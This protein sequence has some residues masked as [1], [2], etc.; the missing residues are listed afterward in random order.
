[1]TSQRYESIG[2]RK[3]KFSSIEAEYPTWMP[4]FTLF[5]DYFRFFYKNICGVDHVGRDRWLTLCNLALPV[6]LKRNYTGLTN[7]VDMLVY[8]LVPFHRYAGGD[9]PGVSAYTIFTEV[10]GRLRQY[11]CFNRRRTSEFLGGWKAYFHSCLPPFSFTPQLYRGH[12]ASLHYQHHLASLRSHGGSGPSAGQGRRQAH[13]FGHGDRRPVLP[14]RGGKDRRG[15]A[16]RSG[17]SRSGWNAG[18]GRHRA[19]TRRCAS[20]LLGQSRRLPTTV[21]HVVWEGAERRGVPAGAGR[22]HQ[23]PQRGQPAV[24]QLALLGSPR[25]RWRDE[26]RHALGRRCSPPR[27]LSRQDSRADSGGEY[28]QVHLP[29]GNLCS[30][31]RRGGQARAEG[32]RSVPVALQCG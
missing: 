26:Q 15:R 20:V 8:S 9:T 1:M 18:L 4:A 12:H 10:H 3:A 25:I 31:L 23:L 28:P 32:D 27:L 21:P 11:S 24:L 29:S 7:S 13:R 22:Q 2:V 17:S 14:D 19:S 16:T 30:G 5:Y 6:R